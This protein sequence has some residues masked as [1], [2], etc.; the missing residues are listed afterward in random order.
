MQSVNGMTKR[1]DIK[2]AAGIGAV[3]LGLVV[4]LAGFAGASSGAIDTT[5]PD[6]TNEITHESDV[7][8]NLDNRNDLNLDNRTEQEASSGDVE[9]HSN[10]TGGDADSGSASNAN[11][12]SATVEIDNSGAASVFSGV[13]GSNGSNTASVENT[14]PNSDNEVRF[15][16]RIDLNV[17]NNND[18][19]IDNNTEQSAQSGSAEVRNNTTGGGA[20]SGNA[21]NTSSSSFTVRIS[22]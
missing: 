14:G 7:D 20:S 22:N 18:V 17:D 15:E 8:L 13:T 5:G 16:S 6:S 11:A 1:I 4:G 12:V 2:K 21:S 9:V 3:S 19:R 10:T